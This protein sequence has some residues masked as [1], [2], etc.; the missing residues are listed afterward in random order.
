MIIQRDKYTIQISDDVLA[1]L[2]SYK[3]SDM[4]KEA[5]GIILGTV[6][7]KNEITISKL[8]LPNVYDRAS[9]YN[10]ERDKTVAQIIINYEFHNSQG[11]IIYLGE[12]HT[13]SA[14]NPTP[15]STDIKM[16]KGQFQDNK[17]NESFLIMMI[18]GTQSLYTALYDGEYIYE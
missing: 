2:D 9:R 8:S 17:L 3:N 10:F 15:S 4:R 1:I 6:S 13:H 18:Q 11:K 16:I 12:W 14:P 5:G 7:R